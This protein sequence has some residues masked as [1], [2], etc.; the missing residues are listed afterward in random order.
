MRDLLFAHV[1]Y[2][3][4]IAISRRCSR[5]RLNMKT[6][7]NS[8][9]CQAIPDHPKLGLCHCKQRERTTICRVCTGV[10]VVRMRGGGTRKALVVSA[11]RLRTQSGETR[12][13]LGKPQ[14]FVP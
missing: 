12:P 9:S 6:F 2:G 5:P 11:C 3:L 1:R 10:S 7:L 13:S 14:G 8:L 4:T